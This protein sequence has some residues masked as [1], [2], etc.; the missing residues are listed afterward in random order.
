M[1]CRSRSMVFTIKHLI[2]GG[3]ILPADSLF[4]NTNKEHFC[5]FNLTL[6]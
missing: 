3:L 2:P 1:D 4:H 5:L 6:R